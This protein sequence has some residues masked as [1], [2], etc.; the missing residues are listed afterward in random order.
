ME[1][2]DQKL[3]SILDKYPTLNLSGFGCHNPNNPVPQYDPTI[4]GSRAFK[5]DRIR[6][7]VKYIP[8]LTVPKRRYTSWSSYGMKHHVEHLLKNRV[9][10]Y[11][12]NGEL[13]FAMIAYGYI[14]S[15]TTTLNCNFKVEASFNEN[16]RLEDYT[17]NQLIARIKFMEAFHEEKDEVRD[18]NQ[19]EVSTPPTQ[20]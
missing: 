11:V 6:L 1:L 2:T 14:P 13:I 16:R 3:Q 20:S 15:S 5:F 12:S 7:I 4:V 8:Y 17:R 10:N 9:K 19:P 18:I